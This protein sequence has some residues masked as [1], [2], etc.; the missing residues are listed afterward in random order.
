MEEEAL[1]FKE[2]LRAPLD[3]AT[4]DAV[5]TPILGRAFGTCPE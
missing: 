1:L 2:I 4:I 3:G 5:A